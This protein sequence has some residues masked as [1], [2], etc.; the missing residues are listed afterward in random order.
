MICKMLIYNHQIYIL[1]CEL[2]D[3]F[4]NLRCCFDL[5]TRQLHSFF[6]RFRHVNQTRKRGQGTKTLYCLITFKKAT[7]LIISLSFRIV[8]KEWYLCSLDYNVFACQPQQQKTHIIHQI[9]NHK[10]PCCTSH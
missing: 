8:A 2:I 6:A 3:E 4:K 1:N 5:F 7:L 10:L 9:F